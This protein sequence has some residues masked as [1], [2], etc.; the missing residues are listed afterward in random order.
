MKTR[1]SPNRSSTVGE[2]GSYCGAASRYYNEGAN[3]RL[4]KALF[5]CGDALFLLLVSISAT[6]VMHLIHGLEWGMTISLVSGMIV[7]MSIQTLL[8]KFVAPLLGSIESMVPS[9]VIAMASPMAVCGFA[10]AGIHLDMEKSVEVGVATGA[11]FFVLMQAYGIRCK[12]G[13]RRS[14]PR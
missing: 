1:F 3:S 11:V 14:F 5:A 10:L 13:L 2:P 12:R 7:A 9:M 6:A 8:A 4:R